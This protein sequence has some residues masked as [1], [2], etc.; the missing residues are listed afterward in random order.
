[1]E[2]KRL[3][4][5]TTK[6]FKKIND[7]SMKNIF[8][9]KANAK[10]RPNDIEVRYHKTTS[11]GDESLNILGPKICSM[12]HPSNMQSETSLMKFEEYINTWFGPK[13][14][15]SIG[16]MI[17]FRLDFSY[18]YLFFMYLLYTSCL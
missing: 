16:R 7:I 9:S 1:M 4:V 2:I 18:C 5:L 11:Y 6:I 13:C 10:V 15:C 12:V 14:K 8:I 3:R 17:D